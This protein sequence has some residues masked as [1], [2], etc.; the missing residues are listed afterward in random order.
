MYGAFFLIGLISSLAANGNLVAASQ[1]PLLYLLNATSGLTVAQFDLGENVTCVTSIPGGFLVSTSAENLTHLVLVTN[2]T[3]YPIEDIV[4]GNESYP[5]VTGTSLDCAYYNGTAVV[6]VRDEEG[7]KAY[8]FK[9]NGTTATL[10]KE[11]NAPAPEVEGGEALLFFGDEGLYLYEGNAVRMITNVT[12][13]D[14]D[15]TGGIVFYVHNGTLN[16]F[17]V[18]GN[19]TVFVWT[20]EKGRA[21][22]VLALSPDKAIVGLRGTNMGLVLVENGATKVAVGVPEVYDVARGE[23]YVAAATAGGLGEGVATV[24]LEWFLK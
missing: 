2:N 16:A 5:S 13:R 24:P 3:Y 1:G 20:P 8:F 9:L 11:V 19:V 22:A 23:G 14:A 4:L 6:T 12:V 15:Y 17:S 18:T 10:V 7:L 21:C